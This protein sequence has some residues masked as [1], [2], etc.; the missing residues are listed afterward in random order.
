MDVAQKT[1]AKSPA[2]EK[3]APIVRRFRTYSRQGRTFRVFDG[4]RA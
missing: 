3:T 1:A 2:E 4:G